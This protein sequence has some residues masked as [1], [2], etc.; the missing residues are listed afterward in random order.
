[1]CGPWPEQSGL[2]GRAVHIRNDFPEHLP[3]GTVGG[4]NRDVGEERL[5]V[6]NYLSF[7]AS[8]GPQEVRIHTHMP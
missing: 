2:R 7:S 5:L 8:E 3:E 4:K 1:M 6:G